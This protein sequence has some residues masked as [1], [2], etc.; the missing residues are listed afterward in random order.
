MLFQQ[1]WCRAP[2]GKKEEEDK[3]TA[4]AGVQWGQ[5]PRSSEAA[6]GDGS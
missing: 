5:E 6:R 2:S 1:G 3:V 4:G